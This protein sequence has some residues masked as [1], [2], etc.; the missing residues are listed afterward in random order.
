MRNL[1]DK[2]RH[3]P[4]VHLQLLVSGTH[5]VSEFGMTVN[6]IEEDGHFI[7]ERIEMLLASD[8]PGGI[9]KSMGLAITCY[10]EALLRLNPDVLVVLGDRFE[11]FCCVVSAQVCRIPVAHIHGGERTEGAIDEAFRHAMT[12]MSLLH[13]PCCEE[14]KSRIIQLGESPDRVFNVGS[15]SIENILNTKLLTSAELQ[16]SINWDC[17]KNY[18]LVTFHPVTL[19][20]ES[21]ESQFIVLLKA[22]DQFPSHRIIMTGTNADTN[23]KPIRMLAIDY[24]TKNK[25]RVLFIES[26]GMKR[27][28][29]SLKYCD[30]VIGNSSSGLLE[31]PALHVPTVNIGDRQKGRL[32]PVSVVDCNPTEIEI[33]SAIEKCLDP[34]FREFV[35]TIQLPMEQEGTTENIID[36]LCSYPF[37]NSIK[38][39]FFDFKKNTSDYT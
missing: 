2:L 23:C 20:S 17:E 31:A 25:D 5:L 30:M 8:T 33:V 13:F 7:A 22:L 3:H 34:V 35:K 27:Y 9:C 10:G 4:N 14:Y 24:A 32:K 6:E 19:E 28:L 39:T 18:F 21:S 12:K 1:I 38:K 37:E 36:I 16:K 29:S 11:S 26:L 15:L